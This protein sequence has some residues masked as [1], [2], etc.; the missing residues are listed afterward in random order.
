MGWNYS[1]DFEKK[2]RWIKTL[3]WAHRAGLSH[4][5]PTLTD[6]NGYFVDQIST[7]AIG[8]MGGPMYLAWNYSTK[9]RPSEV[10]AIESMHQLHDRWAEIAGDR[11]VFI[12]RPRCF[13][14]RKLRRLI[15]DVDA[16]SD[17]PWGSWQSLPNDERRREFTR[18]RGRINDAISPHHVDHIDFFEI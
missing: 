6:E 7:Y 16:G 5:I 3:D 14:G 8:P 11:L 9:T 13:S 18:L 2:E 10:G 12:S 1:N 4:L 15:I 17:S